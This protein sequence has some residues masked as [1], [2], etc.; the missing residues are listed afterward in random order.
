MERTAARQQKTPF[1]APQ[2]MESN[3]PTIAQDIHKAATQN[4]NSFPAPQNLEAKQ[5]ISIDDAVRQR[6]YELYLE[7]GGVPGDEVRDWLQAERELL[8]D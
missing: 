6:A 8:T 3:R 1:P 4:E 7:R 2:K 5:P